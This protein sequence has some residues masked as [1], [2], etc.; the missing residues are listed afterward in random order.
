MSTIS[1]VIPEERAPIRRATLRFRYMYP[2]KISNMSLLSS[3]T[4]SGSIVNRYMKSR[5]PISPA[6]RHVWSAVR[7]ETGSGKTSPTFPLVYIGNDFEGVSSMNQP[8]VKAPPSRYGKILPL[9]VYFCESD[10]EER[11]KECKARAKITTAIPVN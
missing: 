10:T 7:G 3:S 6:P 4:S 11:R 2:P 5:T 1:G 9:V 8:I